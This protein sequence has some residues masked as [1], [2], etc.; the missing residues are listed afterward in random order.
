MLSKYHATSRTRLPAPPP[1]PSPPPYFTARA[2]TRLRT[3][4]LLFF[5]PFRNKMNECERRRVTHGEYFAMARDGYF[6]VDEVTN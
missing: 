4:R 5:P 2:R 3:F 6:I 1:P